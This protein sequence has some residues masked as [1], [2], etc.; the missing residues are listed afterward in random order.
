VNRYVSSMLLGTLAIIAAGPALAGTKAFTMGGSALDATSV[1]NQSFQGVSLGAA[2]NDGVLVNINLP[3]DYQKN[4]PVS[5]KARLLTSSTSCNV[6]LK[7]GGAYR[8][9]AG[10]VYEAIPGTASGFTMDGSATVA[11]P[12]AATKIFT[13]GFTLNK[14]STGPLAGQLA[15]DNIILAFTRVG[16]DPAD[17]CSGN[18]LVTSVRI[19]Y[20]T[21]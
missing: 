5:V 10:E 11:V 2:G 12:A 15:K 18:L 19:V 21:P 13:K 9:R 17:T 1:A 6:V 8:L 7:I 4:S 20:Q 16:G 3:D 14:P